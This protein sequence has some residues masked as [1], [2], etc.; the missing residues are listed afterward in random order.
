M[1][2]KLLFFD[3]ETTGNRSEDRLC[4]IAYKTDDASASLMFKPPLPIQIEAM[5]IHHITNK[6]VDAMPPFQD[7]EA[8]KYLDERAK[9]NETIFIA[10]NAAFD[11]AIVKR[12]G[13][14]PSNH[15]C[16]LKV[17]RALDS[18][19]KIPSYKLQYLRYM[20]EI[21]IEAVAHDAMGD[22][23]VLEKV[24]GHLLEEMKKKKGVS[25]DEAIQMMIEISAKPSLM[26]HI[27][28]GKHKGKT[29]EEVAKSDRGY[30]QWLYAEKSKN[31][32]DEA[33]WLHTLEYYLK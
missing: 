26:K 18:E 4:Q 11:L 17:V 15:I 25:D 10:H 20:L 23:L 28:F 8:H 24:F 1:P 33:D 22:V 6:M 12:E 14:E 3:T 31:P 5:T 7:S 16:T 2:Y 30:L 21:E 19:N 9:E 13:I 29:I 27:N 32:A